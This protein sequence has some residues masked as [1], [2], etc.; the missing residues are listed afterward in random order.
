MEGIARY[1]V[2]IVVRGGRGGRGRGRWGGGGGGL[3]LIIIQCGY[4]HCPAYS[5]SIGE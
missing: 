3:L 4:F 5:A 2:R 1:S